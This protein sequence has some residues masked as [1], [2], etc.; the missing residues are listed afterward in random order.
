MGAFNLPDMSQLGFADIGCCTEGGGV[1]YDSDA[2]EG[3]E[4]VYDSDATEGEEGVGDVRQI[5]LKIRG[6]VVWA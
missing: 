4:G 3:E 6:Y 5:W 2:T 1:D